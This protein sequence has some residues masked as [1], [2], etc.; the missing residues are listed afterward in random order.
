[1]RKL[2]QGILRIIIWVKC[3]ELRM[4]LQRDRQILMRISRGWSMRSFGI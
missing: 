1:M 4:L 2:W 3:F